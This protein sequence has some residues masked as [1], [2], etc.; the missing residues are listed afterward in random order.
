MTQWE[1]GKSLVDFG[2]VTPELSNGD[3]KDFIS[4]NRFWL[5]KQKDLK[6]LRLTWDR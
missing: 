1:Q 2:D 5:F 3:L 4:R 6:T